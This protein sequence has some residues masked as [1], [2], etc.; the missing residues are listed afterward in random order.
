MQTDL[1]LAAKI[2][3]AAANAA[4]PEILSR[5]RNVKSQSKD[6]GSPVTEA[7]IAA[8]KTI[9]SI[10]TE[11]FP[12]IPIKGEELGGDTTGSR[13][14]IVDPIDGTLS[15]TRGIPLFGTLI[16]LVEEGETQVGLIDLPA[17]DERLLATRGGGTTMNGSPVRVS[18]EKQLE[19]AI[20]SCSDNY[21]F[22]LW[23]ARPM[24]NRL[25]ESAPKLRA[26]TDAFGHTQTICGRIDAMVDLALKDWDI[27]PTRLLVEEAGGRCHQIDRSDR[28]DYGFGLIFGSPPL[29]EILVD[30]FQELRI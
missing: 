26:Y 23:Q 9:R 15:F 21:C 4:R 19:N 28:Y 1:L 5:F 18:Q 20:I 29:V 2:A 10:L 11:A 27:A 17:L 8:E 12:D 7:D 13:Y 25:V 6:D 22:D 24:L 3:E 30:W 14:W 16:A